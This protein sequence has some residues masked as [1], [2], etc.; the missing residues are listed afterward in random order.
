MRR[1]RA[2]NPRPP[3]HLGIQRHRENPVGILRT[4][5]RDPAGGKVKHPQHGRFTGLPLSTLHNVQAARSSPNPPWLV[6]YDIS[7]S[8]FEGQHEGREIVQFPDNRDGKRG[9]E[10]V[11][12]TSVEGCPVA[13]E[14]FPGNT[15]DASTV[16]GKVKE[17]RGRY[18]LCRNPHRAAR[19]KPAAA[20]IFLCMLADYLQWHLEPRT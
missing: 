4:T 18:C 1:F 17:L 11:V 19:E 2:I 14:V 3:I 12:L 10:Q 5:L 6:L 7:S 13:V 15:Q 9:H 8:H 20:L 16:E